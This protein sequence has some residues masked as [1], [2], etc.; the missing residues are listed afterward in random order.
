MRSR[1]YGFAMVLTL[2]VSALLVACGEQ[3]TPVSVSPTVSAPP[4]SPVPSSTDT[5]VPP[6]ASTVAPPTATTAPAG[7]KPAPTEAPAPTEPPAAPTEPPAAPTGVMMEADPA[8]VVSIILKEDNG[9]GQSGW[10]ALRAKGDQTEVMLFLPSG[11]LEPNWSIFM[12]LLWRR[13][14]GRGGARPHQLR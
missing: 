2:V 10:A 11:N 4:T 7:T 3:A 14:P 12:R 8:G 9:S 5:P 6:P 13:Y 1:V